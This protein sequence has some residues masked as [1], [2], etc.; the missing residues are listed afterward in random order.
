VLIDSDTLVYRVAFAVQET[1]YKLHWADVAPEAEDDPYA[2]RDHWTRFRYKWRLD[3]YMRLQ[4]LSPQEVTIT[5]H[6]TAEPVRH[7]LHVM[8]D[9]LE[10][11][12]AAVQGAMADYP[13]LAGRPVQPELYLSGTL[14]FRDNVATIREYK[15]NRDR[16]LRPV[17]YKA[18]RDY[19]VEHWDAAIVEG[20]EAD[21]AVAIEQFKAGDE[22]D[23][24]TIIA[25]IDKDLRMV[26]G[27]HYNTLT[28]RD[29]LVTREQAIRFFYT[30]LLTGD[31]TDNIPGLFRVGEKKAAKM[32]PPEGA[33]EQ[34]LYKAVLDAY[35]ENLEKFG[36][37]AQARERN[38]GRH[39]EPVGLLWE[40]A[41]LLWMLE[42]DDQ[43]WTAPGMPDESIK[44]AGLLVQEGGDEF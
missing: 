28:A 8:K 2:D 15:G 36:D 4:N 30:Q 12:L 25:T 3:E 21:D 1:W 41:R 26:P 39:E 31:Q 7:A 35:A 9:Q 20:Y 18:L 37:N 33:S 43:L 44:G 14:N 23:V 22:Y 34:E 38:F 5:P 27:W 11:I 19:L 42:H 13:E 24:N 29:Y 32:L 10:R 16:D 6:V 40:N 17:H